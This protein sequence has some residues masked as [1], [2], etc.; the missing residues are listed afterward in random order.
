MKDFIR[1]WRSLSYK[2]TIL[3][4]KRLRF[5]I[6]GVE[7]NTI[8]V[9]VHDTCKETSFDK[10]GD[11]STRKAADTFRGPLGGKAIAM[12]P[13]FSTNVNHTEQNRS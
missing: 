11:S 8:T 2:E 7:S 10:V 4:R 1:C 5:T 3:H 6:A 12:L 9:L 13:S